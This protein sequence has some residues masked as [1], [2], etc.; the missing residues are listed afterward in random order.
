MR[1][2]GANCKVPDQAHVTH[3]SAQSTAYHVMPA[4]I[5]SILDVECMFR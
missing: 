4:F 3:M 1:I 5:K 2:Y